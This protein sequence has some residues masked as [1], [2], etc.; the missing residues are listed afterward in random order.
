MKIEIQADGFDSDNKLSHFAIC[1]AG[2][3][4]GAQKDQIVSLRVHLADA[5]ELRDGKDQCCFVE[6][7]LSD[8]HKIL[9]KAMDLDFHIAIY[10][11]L[12]RAGGMVAQRQQRGYRHAGRAPTPEIPGLREPNWAA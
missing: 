11:A 3:E 2:F 12:E 9:T 7:E 1:C 6:I 5:S 4:L 8:G 10:Q